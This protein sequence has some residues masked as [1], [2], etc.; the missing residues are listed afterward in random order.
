MSDHGFSRRYF[1]YG[2]L[3]AGAVPLGG[4]GSM[5]SLKAAGYK[6]PN[7]KLNLAAIGAGGQPASD[8]R[9]AHAGTENVVALADVDVIRGNESF[10]RFPKAAKFRDFRQML[11]KQGKDIDA[12]VIG[13]PDHMHAY[14][15]LACMQQGKHVYVE[16]PLTRTSWEARILTQAAEKYKVATQMGNQGYSHDATRVACEIFWSGEIGEV[17]EVHAWSGRPSWPQE[18]TKIPPPTPVPETL[19]WD[20]WLGGAAMRPFTAGDEEYRKFVIERAMRGRPAGAPPAAPPRVVPPQD[21]FGFYLPFNWRGFYDFGSSLI[22]DWGVH[23]LGPANWALQ[24]DPQYLVSVECIKKN[25]L[26]A[27]TFPD[28]LAIRYDFAARQG[29][30]PVSIFWY[31]HA[32]GDAYTPP[33]MT[34]EDAR[35]LPGQGPQVGPVSGQGGFVPGSGGAPPTAPG[36]PAA[37][38]PQGP[39]RRPQGSGYNSIFVGSKGY[40]GTSGRGEGVG[41]LPG[42]KWAEY[43]LPAPYLQ[44]SPG[45]ST[46]SNHSA[47]TRDWVR[48]CK[49]GAPACS[50]FAI[51]GKYTEWLVL[52]A[53][54]VHVDGKLMWDNAKGEFTNSKEANKWVKPTFRKGWEVK[55]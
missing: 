41:L 1:F 39:P 29:M 30:P 55:L 10:E 4:F 12:V 11:D 38:P 34:V 46:G 33:G 20:L 9:S 51:A 25:S 6:S 32:G 42:S 27:F 52:G 23:I 26:P 15:A 49:G 43:K 44:R 14:C 50:N 31:H 28:E 13:T 17:N 48:A 18:M 7:E 19:D 21:N 37:A 36:A 45:A 2:S 16:K 3:L 47:H 53:A 5:Q 8:L 40:M 35:K 22:G 54:A 24:L